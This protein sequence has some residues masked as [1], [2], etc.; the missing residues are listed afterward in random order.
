MKIAPFFYFKRIIKFG[1]QKATANSA[2]CKI[3]YR[4][5]SAPRKDEIRNDLYV[6]VQ[7]YSKVFS[8]HFNGFKDYF[9]YDYYLWENKGTVTAYVLSP[10]CTS[11]SWTSDWI[12]PV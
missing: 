5:I 8:D 2:D 6:Q 12:R 9:S 1:I 10:T 11:R 7:V 3:R 4:V